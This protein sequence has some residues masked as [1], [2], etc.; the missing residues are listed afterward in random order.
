MSHVTGCQYFSERHFS[1]SYLNLTVLWNS[2]KNPCE[3]QSKF[4]PHQFHQQW[5]SRNHTWDSRK[6]S[7]Q[8]DHWVSASSCWS[9]DSHYNQHFSSSSLA[10][11][12]AF[13]SRVTRPSEEKANDHVWWKNY[14]WL[15][16]WKFNSRKWSR[17]TSH[18]TRT[19]KGWGG[20]VRGRVEGWWVGGQLWGREECVASKGGTP[21][22]LGV[23]T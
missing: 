4:R 22:A 17:M 10:P 21:I 1:I 14:S 15:K 9:Q 18:V 16:S 8:W 5:F 7:V 11:Q 13:L 23:H 6:Y 12:S 3:L 2:V 19:A 20:G